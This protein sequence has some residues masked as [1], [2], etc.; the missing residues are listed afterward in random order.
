MRYGSAALLVTAI[1]C[2]LGGA[3][4]RAA[5][6]EVRISAP[7]SLVAG[8]SCRVTVSTSVR[9]TVLLQER[10]GKRWR[11]VST[12]RLRRRSV[13]LRCPTVDRAGRTRLL[14]ALVRRDG[15]TVGRSR[16]VGIR[17][18]DAPATPP[19]VAVPGR[20]PQAPGPD[21]GAPAPP[22]PT[23][24]DPA[25]FGVEGTGGP[26]SPEALALLAN[27]NVVLDADGSADIRAGR[28]DPRIVA[29]LTK[30]SEAHTITV[31]AM[32]S[33][34]P[35]FTSGGS[36]SNHY[37]GRGADIAAIDG[38]PIGP[39]NATAR[40]VASSLAAFDP[41]YRPDEIGTP[42]AIPGPGYFTDAASQDK[43][44]VAFKQ[45]IDPGWTPPG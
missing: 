36:V 19:P 21:R 8:K 41:S 5:G 40:E 43:I 25:Q 22:A 4:S 7:A 18:R 26:P 17:M 38:R 31:S 9:G 24:L 29:V 33:D 3:S 44:H 6:S 14:R 32:C 15:R 20:P 27:R 45:P 39:A 28:I 12:A 1:V 34:H 2:W 23:R 13:T 30:L 42:W 35:K 10:T 11:T 37:F 16:T